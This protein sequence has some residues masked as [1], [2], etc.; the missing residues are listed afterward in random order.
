MPTETLAE[1]G[2][3]AVIDRTAVGV[4]R[5]HVAEGHATSEA[6]VRCRIT[7]GVEPGND[8]RRAIACVMHS[9]P[10]APSECTS[11]EDRGIQSAR[12]EEVHQRR[13]DKGTSR[14]DLPALQPTT[15]N[16][17]AARA[18][19]RS[20]PERCIVGVEIRDHQVA[21]DGVRID[22]PI[23]VVSAIEVVGEAESESSA[24][25]ALDGEVRLLRVGVDEVLRLRVAE[26]LKTQRQERRGSRVRE[27]KLSSSG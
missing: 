8:C 15:V 13:I 10:C 7:G 23:Q 20:V 22:R 25:I 16:G 19:A 11:A 5:V 18:S 1:V 14:S 4:V 21:A 2:A 12:P 17:L 26:G 6:P 9:A 24:K 3:E 27:F